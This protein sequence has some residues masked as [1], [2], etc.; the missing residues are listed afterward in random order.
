M[1]TDLAQSR[2]DVQEVKSPNT[3]ATPKGIR[4]EGSYFVRC[5]FE[6][7]PHSGK[8]VSKETDVQ[9][10]L[11]GEPSRQLWECILHE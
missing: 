10:E 11:L 6:Q 9:T 3:Q 7:W 4:P 1:I 8:Q 2:S 5:R